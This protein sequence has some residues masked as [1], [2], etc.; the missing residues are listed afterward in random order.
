MKENA[1]IGTPTRGDCLTC[2]FPYILNRRATLKKKYKD[3]TLKK[4]KIACLK[5]RTAACR[6][7]ASS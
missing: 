1:I 3:V 5:Q 2:H 6:A 7:A 4:M